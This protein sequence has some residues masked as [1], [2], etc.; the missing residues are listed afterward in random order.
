MVI[1]DWDGTL[2]DSAGHIVRAMRGAAREVGVEVPTEDAV[3]DIIGLGLAEAGAILFPR[4]SEAGLKA[5]AEA[6]S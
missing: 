6:Y 1:F 2:C 5:V 3:R 4:E